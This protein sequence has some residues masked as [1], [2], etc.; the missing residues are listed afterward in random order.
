MT[1]HTSLAQ[2]PQVWVALAAATTTAADLLSIGTPIAGKCSLLMYSAQNQA[3]VFTP[4]ACDA[5]VREMGNFKGPAGNFPIVVD[6]AFTIVA[7]LS[8]AA[9]IAI[10]AIVAS[11]LVTTVAIAARAK[12]LEVVAYIV[13]VLAAIAATTAVAAGSAAARHITFPPQQI[14]ATGE[15]TYIIAVLAAANLVTLTIK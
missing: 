9:A 10:A 7:T 5:F 11:T 1:S 4:Y 2:R 13:A 6:S 8:S 3:T 14:A 12:Q 15:G